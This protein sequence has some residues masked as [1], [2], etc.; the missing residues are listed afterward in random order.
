MKFSYNWLKELSGTGKSVQEVAEE[1]TLCSFEVED[2]IKLGKGLEKVVVGEVLSKEQHPDA[3]RLAVAIISVGSGEQL[4]IVCGA[5]N[6]AVGQKVPVALIGAILPTAD[7]KGFQ[8]KQ[9]EIRGVQ[10]NGMICAQD[11]LGLGE[12]HAGIMVLSADAPI[13]EDF[14]Q[15]MGLDDTMIDIDILPNRAH[16]C[17]AHVG[18][19][20]EIA[21][22]EGRN[23]ESTTQSLKEVQSNTLKINVTTDKCVRYTATAIN[24]VDNTVMTPR[25]MTARLTACGLRSVSPIVDITNY[26]MLETGQPLHAFDAQQIAQDDVVDIS[27]RTATEGEKIVLLDDIEIELSQEDIVIVDSA[28]PIA[29]AGVMGGA[30]SSVSET[31]TQIVL[32]VA[33]FDATTIR[34][35]RTRYGITSDAAYRFERD[36][37]P[38]LVVQ[39]QARA[40]ELI[41]QICGGV[42]ASSAEYYPAPVTPWTVAVTPKEITRLLGIEIETAQI[43]EI[44]ASIGIEVVEDTGSL[45]CTIPTVRRDMRTPEDVIEEIG[46][47]YGYG[48]IVPQS[49]VGAITA[50]EKNEARS[51][52]YTVLDALVGMG[53]DE[54]KSYSFYARNTATVLGLDPDT[55]VGLINPMNPD[56]ALMRRTL[57]AHLLG[58][59]RT[60]LTHIDSVTICEIG[61]T[62]LPTTNELPREQVV[63]GIAVASKDVN[64]AQFFAVKGM[65]VQLLAR[66]GLQDYRIITQPATED[67]DSVNYHPSRRALI[68]LPDDTIIGAIGEATKKQLKYFGIKKSRVSTAEIDMKLLRKSAAS[69]RFFTPISKF[70][71]V[72]RDLS[73]IVP[74]RLPVADVERVLY[75]TAKNSGD[76]VTDIDLF[77]L[78]INPDTEE[79]SM[80]FHVT[81]ASPER[82]LTNKEIDSQITQMIAVVEKELNISVRQ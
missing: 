44:L 25:W 50:P 2:I 55:H 30:G 54:V 57:T 77:D 41:A 33:S 75:D 4:Q 1:L 74:A 9:S 76:L 63:C 70:P 68:M 32:E 34:T 6:L 51:F 29:L 18:V 80:A 40:I 17:L 60:N 28:Q 11:E 47:L 21:A 16:D 53:C 31:T 66:I 71:A 46:R 27:V 42:V 49:L 3:D 7:G 5:P 45:I 61:K 26:V 24:N 58:A 65:I 36:I 72:M 43:R 14:A 20:Q 48:N 13:G 79:R 62:Y 82:T 69:D 8:I 10:S 22:I 15:F 19:A 73:M 52:Q 59:A 56:Q 35:T 37:D 23:I 78:Y 67:S 12:E 39:A 38:N 64:G 81:F